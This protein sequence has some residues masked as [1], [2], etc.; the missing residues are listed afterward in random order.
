A[1]ITSGQNEGT[2]LVRERHQNHCSQARLHVFLR[3]V[4]GQAF[5]NFLELSFENLKSVG[6]GNLKKFYAEVTREC[7]CVLDAAARRIWAWHGNAG[8]VLRAQRINC[9]DCRDGGIDS[10]AQTDNCRVEVAFA[11]VIAEP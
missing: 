4:F 10:A 2:E 11:A 9:D 5:E 1:L 3:L 8:Y 7:P 6:D